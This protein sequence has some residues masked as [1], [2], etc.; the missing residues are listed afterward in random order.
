MGW[1]YAT[2]VYIADWAPGVAT[3]IVDA[4]VGELVRLAPQTKPAVDGGKTVIID[5]DA[6]HGVQIVG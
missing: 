5:L 4:A 2:I 6:F 3:L 1:D